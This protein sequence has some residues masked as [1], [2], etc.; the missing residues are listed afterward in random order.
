MRRGDARRYADTDREDAAARANMYTFLSAVF[1][2]PPT[3]DLVRQIMDQTFLTDLSALFSREAVMELR[4]FAANASVDADLASLRQ[5][6]MDLFAV[7]T[8]RYVTPFEDVY[9]GEG[10]DG[11]LERG[12]L[13]GE[14]AIAVRRLYRQAGAEMTR[15]CRELPTHIGVELSFM[16]FLCEREREAISRDDAGIGSAE[17]DGATGTPG[18]YRGLQLRFLQNHLN[19]WFP[20]LRKAIQAHAKSRLYPGLA[21]ITEEFLLR[22]AGSFCCYPRQPEMH[23]PAPPPRPES[24]VGPD[25]R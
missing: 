2:H 12:P 1:L 18:C 19:A 4:R 14:R 10:I 11:A 3:G 25:G 16:A 6:Y 17:T 13:L 20:Q 24:E 15:E 9:Q 8:G 5:E 23:R 22:D 7:P 21:L